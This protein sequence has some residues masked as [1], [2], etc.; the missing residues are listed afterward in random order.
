M[1]FKWVRR[2]ALYI[3]WFKATSRFALFTRVAR[4][5]L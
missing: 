5:K 2:S 1:I 3:E 4:Q